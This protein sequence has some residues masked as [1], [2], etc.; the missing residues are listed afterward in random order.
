[1]DCRDISQYRMDV[2][3]VDNGQSGH[4]IAKNYDIRFSAQ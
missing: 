1:M 2:E 4:I 3:E